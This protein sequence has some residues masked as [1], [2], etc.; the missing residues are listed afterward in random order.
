MYNVQYRSE[1]EVKVQ[2]SSRADR[3]VG[4]R[5]SPTWVFDALYP[6]DV[7]PQDIKSQVDGCLESVESGI[8]RKPDIERADAASGS[9]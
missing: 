8:S 1:E 9:F 4:K 2:D 6:W 3:D 7:I 5:E